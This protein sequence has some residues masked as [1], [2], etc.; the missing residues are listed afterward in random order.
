MTAVS[1]IIG[2]L[3]ERSNEKYKAGMK[4]F[5]IADEFALGIPLPELVSGFDLPRQQPPL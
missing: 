4:R 5:G 2:I 3:K 1:E